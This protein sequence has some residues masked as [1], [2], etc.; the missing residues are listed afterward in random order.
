[1]QKVGAYFCMAGKANVWNK[2]IAWKTRFK[3]TSPS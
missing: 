2:I 1:L 3:P